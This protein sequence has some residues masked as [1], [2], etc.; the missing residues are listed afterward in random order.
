MET[1]ISNPNIPEETRPPPHVSVSDNDYTDTLAKTCA[2]F[3]QT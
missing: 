3:E 1:P 2:I